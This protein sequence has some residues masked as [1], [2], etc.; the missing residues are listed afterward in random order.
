MDDDIHS[1]DPQIFPYRFTRVAFST[2]SSPHILNAVL[3][4]HMENY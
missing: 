4:H 1:E 2:N 3:I